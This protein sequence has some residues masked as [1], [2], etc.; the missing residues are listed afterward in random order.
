MV[1][2]GID[3]PRY[4]LYPLPPRNRRKRKLLARRHPLHPS[5]PSTRPPKDGTGNEASPPST[6]RGTF[7]IVRSETTSTRSVLIDD[8]V[9]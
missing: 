8:L 5:R 1:R 6:R 4:Q 2:F 3:Q 9:V 7:G